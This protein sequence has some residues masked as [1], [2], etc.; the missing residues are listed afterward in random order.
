MSPNKRYAKTQRAQ[1]FLTSE[2]G[3][4]TYNELIKMVEDKGYNTT[5]TFSPSAVDGNLAFIDKH[6]NYLCA[7]LNV[8]ASHYLSNLRLITKVRK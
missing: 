1:L 3:I 2:E 4:A 6:M 5:S 8:N 7:H